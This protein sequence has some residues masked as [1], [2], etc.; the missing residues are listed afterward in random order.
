[1]YVATITIVSRTFDHKT[2]WSRITNLIKKDLKTPLEPIRPSQAVGCTVVHAE[3]KM[4][5]VT[6]FRHRMDQKAIAP[7]KPTPWEFVS[8]PNV[9]IY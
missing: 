7:T 9:Q 4:T 1:M 8:G 3:L 5:R 6:K 2:S